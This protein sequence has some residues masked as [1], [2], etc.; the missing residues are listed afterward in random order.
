M[1]ELYHQTITGS[2]YKTG[3]LAFKQLFKIVSLDSTSLD[4]MHTVPDFLASQSV[5]TFSILMLKRKKMKFF[6]LQCIAY[7]N[8]FKSF[9]TFS[10]LF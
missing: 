7:I 4:T 2:V 9:I 5:R 1:Y 8:D 3:M 10:N 6:Y